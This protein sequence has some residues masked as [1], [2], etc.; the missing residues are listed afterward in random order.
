MDSKPG[1]QV[2]HAILTDDY[3]ETRWNSLRSLRVISLTRYP[4][5]D[6]YLGIRWNWQ[7]KTMMSHTPPGQW[8]LFMETQRQSKTRTASATRCPVMVIYG[9]AETVRVVSAHSC[10]VLVFL[11]DIVGCLDLFACWFFSKLWLTVN[12]VLVAPKWFSLGS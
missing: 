4:S 8:W 6:D 11:F 7:L 2:S 1:W 9:N 10:V 5:S 12:E 3:L